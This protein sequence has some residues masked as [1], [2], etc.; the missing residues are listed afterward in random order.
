MLVTSMDSRV[1]F[2][3]WLYVTKR[4]SQL[5]LVTLIFCFSW[6]E[7]MLFWFIVLLFVSIFAFHSLSCWRIC[8]TIRRLYVKNRE[9]SHPPITN[10]LRIP[11]FCFVWSWEPFMNLII[12]EFWWHGGPLQMTYVISSVCGR[13]VNTLDVRSWRI[14]AVIIISLAIFIVIVQVGMMKKVDKNINTKGS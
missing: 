14:C 6:S 1:M 12:S 3:P 7:D 2:A 8:P 13:K 10:T 5:E 11:L 9:T 4:F